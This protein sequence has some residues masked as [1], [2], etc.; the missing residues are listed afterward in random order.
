[1]ATFNGAVKKFTSKWKKTKQSFFKR[2]NS[3]LIKKD[4][5]TTT[6]INK[7]W[8]ANYKAKFDVMTDKMN[9]EYAK[10][11]SMYH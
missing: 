6:E 2:Y 9:K 7:F 8:N 11:Y 4:F 10:I 3:A 5:S 1:M